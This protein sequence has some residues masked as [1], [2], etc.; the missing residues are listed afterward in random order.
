M[1]RKIFRH[2]AGHDSLRIEEKLFN[3]WFFSCGVVLYMYSF[4]LLGIENT[5]MLVYGGF[6]SGTLSII[7]YFFSRFLGLYDRIITPSIILGLLAMIQQWFTTGGYHSHIPIFFVFIIALLASIFPLEKF[8]M[9]VSMTLTSFLIIILIEAFVPGFSS[10]NQHE[11]TFI[12]II[13]FS[14]LFSISTFAV[15]I[16]YLK[17]SKEDDSLRLKNANI[18]LKKASNIKSQFL[19]NMSHEIR[20]PLHGAMGM[21]SLIK[22][23][24]KSP[25]LTEFIKDLDA[26]QKRLLDTIDQILDFSKIESGVVELVSEEFSIHDITLE[27]QQLFSSSVKSKGLSLEFVIE[28]AVENK[29]WIGDQVKIGQILTNLVNNA[30]KFTEQGHI[31]VSFNDKQRLYIEISDTGIGIPPDKIDQLFDPFQQVDFS[32]SRLYGGTGLGL[33]ICKNLVTAMDGDIYI[34][35]T[36]NSGTTI[37][38]EL[39]LISFNKSKVN[40][41]DEVTLDKIPDGFRILVVDDDRLN[42]RMT[43]R[44]LLEMGFDVS[45]AAGGREGVELAIK[46]AFQLI[47]MDI[48][49]PIQNG[50]ESSIII[51]EHYKNSRVKPTIIAFSA[52]TLKEDIEKAKSIGMVDYLSKPLDQQKLIYLLNQCMRKHQM[53]AS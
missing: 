13:N 37:V 11:T 49:M 47:L 1:L 53:L 39:P 33:S 40:I 28:K 17:K 27:L 16:Y 51:K 23:L 5:P 46:I 12:F 21:T 50:F 36:S 6:I 29:I 30:I 20:T 22:M 8:A 10:T 19:A 45:T 14:I 48:Q 18:Q 7:Y 25:E 32:I 42:L 52:N 41:N 38:V 3:F 4:I 15:L 26:S 31:L 43:E 24:N 44:L 9:G 35:D 34:K 2:I